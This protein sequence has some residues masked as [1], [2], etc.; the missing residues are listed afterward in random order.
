MTIEER[1]KELKDK[2]NH[3]N[4]MYYVLDRPEISDYEYDMMMRELIKLEEEHPEFKTPDSPTQ[5]VGGEPVKEFEPFTHVVVMQSL[6]NAFSE[7]ELRDFDRRVRSSV[8]DVEYVV[9]LKIDG[10]SVELIYENGIFTIG[11]TRGDGFVG[12]NVTNNLK[13]I[14]SIPLR[15]KDN[16]NLIVRGEV[17]MP[18]AS[19]E[20]LNE[21][22]ELNGESLFANPRNAAAGSLRQLNPKI[23]AKRDLDIFVF[24]LQRIEGVELKTHVEALEFLK[25]QGFKVSPHLKKCK[26]IDEVIED[27]NYIR[28][29]RDS[30]PYDTDG[31]VVKV[32]DLEKREILGSTVKDPRWAI[33]FK[34]PAERQKTK[35]KDIIVQVG[36]T[37]ALT[38][39]A[40][41][42][43]VKIAGSIVSRATL[44]NEDY[45]KEKDIRIG[46]TV[47]IQKAGEIIPEV[48]SVVVEDRKGHEKNFFMP[49]TCPECGATTVRLPG[50]AVTRCTGLN[51]PAKLKRG[52]IHF[53]SKDAMDIDGLGPAV[54]GQLLDNHLIHNIA[55]LYYLKYDDLIKLDRMGDKSVKNLLNAIEESKGRDLDRVIF[56]LGIDLIG[57]KAASI[58]ANHFKTMDSLEEAS[59]DE[60]TNIEEVGPKMA[61]SI[62]AFFKEKQNKEILDKLKE[63]GVNMVKKKSENTSNIFDGLTFVLT[64]TLSNYTRDEAKKLIEERGGKVTGSVS[65]KTNYVV[66]GTDPGSKLSK[67]QQLG[68]KVIDE[69]EFENMLKQ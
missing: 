68:V 32:N 17:F 47:I 65:K 60:L 64:G 7:G 29:I 38:P 21:E 43:P 50:E 39:T 61:D 4:Y 11:S 46:D 42:E 67:A 12:E 16:L 3:H 59:F 13:T 25:E 18:R 51:C 40:I 1:I 54:I 28:T 33:A 24:N 6:A 9:E 57:S 20:K 34:Y 56:G 23:T 26:N 53:A 69:E 30:L 49:D 2:L 31:A 45:I 14:K 5:R 62:I 52:I 27:I 55:D 8:G 48:V 66:A 22:R 36:R 37:G 44:H 41:L 10:L 63:A 35:V 15:L 19:F 58:L